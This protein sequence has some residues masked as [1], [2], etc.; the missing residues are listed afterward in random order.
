[1]ELSDPA[2]VWQSYKPEG[3]NRRQS[4]TQME[5]HDNFSLRVDHDR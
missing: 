4:V 5:G 2:I 1:M 3:P